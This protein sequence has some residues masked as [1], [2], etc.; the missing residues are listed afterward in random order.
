[1]ASTRH[2][3][4][5]FNAAV[6]EKEIARVGWSG[7]VNPT[8][9]QDFMMEVESNYYG[10]K[11][12]YFLARQYT[13]V[14]TRHGATLHHAVT[15][16]LVNSMPFGISDRTAYRAD[17]RFYVGVGTSKASDNLRP[18]KFPNPPPLAGTD[19]MDGWL[20][21]ISCCSGRGQAVFEYDTPWSADGRGLDKIYWQKQ[22]GTVV[23]TIDVTWNDGNGHAF[24]AAGDL[25]QDR[26]ITVSPSGVNLAA[27]Q[28]A[29]ATLPSLSLG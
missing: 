11:A 8:G 22:P 24:K 27:G 10:D 7:A 21:D 1:M 25:S 29:Q 6:A 26:V 15:V 5:Y 23:D 16:D 14:L 17:V 28:P 4:A 19:V 9:A 12:N 3:Q 18:V 20:P 2:V 13:V